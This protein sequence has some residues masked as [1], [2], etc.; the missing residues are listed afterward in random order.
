M[1]YN[2]NH[3]TFHFS[4]IDWSAP[5]KLRYKYMLEGLDK[6]WSPLLEDNRPYTQTYHGELILSR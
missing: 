1:P 3:L 2:L 6:D 5:H 4:A